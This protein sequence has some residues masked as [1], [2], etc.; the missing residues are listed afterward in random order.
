MTESKSGSDRIGGIVAPFVAKAAVNRLRAR[1]DTYGTNKI[2]KLGC[3]FSS[4]FLDEPKR[5][6]NG[7]VSIDIDRIRKTRAV[8]APSPKS[9]PNPAVIESVEDDH[10]TILAIPMSSSSENLKVISSIL[11][12]DFSTIKTFRNWAPIREI[13]AEKFLR[14]LSRKWFAWGTLGVESWTNSLAIVI[15]YFIDEKCIIWKT[16]KKNFKS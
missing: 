16:Q 12:S 11:M 2:C 9:D 4:G 1:Q 13:S 5:V 8:F 3:D 7:R 6:N 15:M 10:S 14:A